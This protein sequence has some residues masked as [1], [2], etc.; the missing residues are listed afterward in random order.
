M[1]FGPQKSERLSFRKLC[2]D[3]ISDTQRV[4]RRTSL[5]DD[6][7]EQAKLSH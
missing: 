3:G 7:T 6:V 1:V 4:P 5:L 2:R